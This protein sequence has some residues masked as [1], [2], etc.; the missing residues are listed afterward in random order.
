VNI[1]NTGVSAL[2][3]GLNINETYF[4]KDDWNDY[5]ILLAERIC[6]KLYEFGGTSNLHPTLALCELHK[7]S[8]LHCY[9]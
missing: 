2:F 5:N 7:V 4:L 6:N 1:D 9:L 3:S 8:R